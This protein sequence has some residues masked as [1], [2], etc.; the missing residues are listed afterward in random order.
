MPLGHSAIFNF[1]HFMCANVGHCTDLICR[2]LLLRS[3]VCEYKLLPAALASMPFGCVL[4]RYCHLPSG[5]W[6]VSF[7]SFENASGYSCA[8]MSFV[9]AS[10][11]LSSSATVIKHEGMNRNRRTKLATRNTWH[12][13][14]VFAVPWPRWQL[15]LTALNLDNNSLLG[16]GSCFGVVFCSWHVFIAAPPPRLHR[17]ARPMPVVRSCKPAVSLH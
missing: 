4:V 14:I 6:A 12:K 11:S 1:T 2:N 8:R 9:N 10:S 5:T 17:T 16:I 15:W 3:C 7:L 13:R